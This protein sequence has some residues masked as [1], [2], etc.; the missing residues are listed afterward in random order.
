MP[1][2]GATLAGL[3]LAG[4]GAPPLRPSNDTPE[5]AGII[6]GTVTITGTT[7]QGDVYLLLFPQRPLSDG[8]C[9]SAGT[10][11]VEPAN[12]VRIDAG[13]V[14]V[15]PD[16][17]THSV[18]FVIPQVAE[19]CYSLGA[20]VD[21]DADLYPLF[22]VTAGATLGDALGGAF[23]EP[24]PDPPA[25]P[26]LRVLEVRAAE[27]IVPSIDGVQV[28]VGATVPLERPSFVIDGLP[29]GEMPSISLTAMGAAFTMSAVPLAYPLVS[30]GDPEGP[31]CPMNTPLF[32]IVLGP[33]LDGDFVPEDLDG[34]M[35]PDVYGTRVLMRRLSD[36]LPA[37]ALADAPW[38]EDVDFP[39][40]IPGVI[41]PTPFIMYHAMV[42]MMP[43]DGM[44]LL[45]ACSLTIQVPPIGVM[46]G[47]F[48]DDPPTIMPLAAWEMMAADSSESPVGA[49]GVLTILTATN[50]T[51]DV[52]NELM[53]L[54]MDPGQAAFFAVTP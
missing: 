6:T 49:Y 27:G 47:P 12:L 43:P 17:D 18:D 25:S 51:W 20:L 22:G 40:V 53:L 42:L 26:T 30:T 48:A 50:Q 31:P 3:A 37:D 39:L 54:A 11:L 32:P 7:A 33:D 44:T 28:L 9:P 13:L 21:A 29:P 15:D 52:P 2:A 23:V 14:F 10:S 35:A 19:G 38:D 45:A 1:L 36:N 34:D 8:S 4:C 5:P 24:I 41:D 16:G 46:P